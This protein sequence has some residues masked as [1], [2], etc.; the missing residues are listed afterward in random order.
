MAYDIV[1][2]S[3]EELLTRINFRVSEKQRPFHF[4][5]T[6]Q[7]IYVPRIKLIAKTDPFYFQR[8]PVS[9]VRFL[10]VRRQPAYV[11][12]FVGALMFLFGA[13]GT[14]SLFEPIFHP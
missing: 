9:Q 12:W 4:A 7:A 8:V 3:G 2:Q 10:N 5:I 6:N 13:F 11:P 14:Y 1:L